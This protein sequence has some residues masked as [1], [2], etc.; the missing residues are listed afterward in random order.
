MRASDHGKRGRLGT[1]CRVKAYGGCKLLPVG[2]S[3]L[4]FMVSVSEQHIYTCYFRSTRR[5]K[6]YVHYSD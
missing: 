6:A 2:T 5:L 3:S 1:M 4:Q